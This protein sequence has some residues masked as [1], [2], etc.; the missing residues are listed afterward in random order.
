MNATSYAW[1]VPAG[2]SISSHPE[3]LGSND[4]V[5][6]VSYSNSFTGGNITVMANGICA[7]SN[8][9]SLAIQ[10]SLKPGTVGAIIANEIQAC[11]DRRVD[12]SIVLP[13]NTNWVQWTVPAN[14]VILNGQG[15]TSITV[16]YPLANA[17]FVTA[18]PSNGCGVGKT[19]SLQVN[20][21]AC[22]T[23]PGFAKGTTAQPKPQLGT[24][25]IHVFPNP[26]QS[27]FNIYVTSVSKERIQAR[28]YDVNGKQYIPGNINI[29]ELTDFGNNLKAGVYLL[30]VIQ[31]S[32][33][34]ITR[35]VKF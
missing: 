11:P 16:S 35:L 3:G 13:S 34:K 8:V 18:T 30:E 31:G 2:A 17:G 33:R 28:L 29:N 24:L 14:A 19:R 12:Y 23:A 15:T 20:L 32:Q 9:R 5:I 10:A 4:T 26:T 27:E 21:T 6:V 1:S 7:S 25:E 22:R